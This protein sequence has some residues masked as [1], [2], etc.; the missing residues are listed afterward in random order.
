[1]EIDLTH[2]HLEKRMGHRG[3]DELDLRRM[4]WRARR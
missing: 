3:F 2:P 4:L 1:M